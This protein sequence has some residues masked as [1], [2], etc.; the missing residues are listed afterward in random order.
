M[1]GFD[2]KIVITIII[3]HKKVLLVKGKGRAYVVLFSCLNVEQIFTD[4]ANCQ[5]KQIVL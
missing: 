5:V 3:N 2:I 1:V 4:F